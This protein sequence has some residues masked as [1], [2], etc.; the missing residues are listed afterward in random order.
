M[1]LKKKGLKCYF[2]LVTDRKKKKK[3]PGK[4][5]KTPKKNFGGKPVKMKGKKKKALKGP[6]SF[7]FNKSVGAGV[8]PKNTKKKKFFFQNAS[9]IFFPGFLKG[10]LLDSPPLAVFLV[11]FGNWAQKWGKK[12]LKKKVPLPTKMGENSKKSLNLGVYPLGGLG[13]PKR[14]KSKKK[15]GYKEIFNDR[16]LPFWKN[17]KK[18]LKRGKKC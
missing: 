14:K 17:L 4:K 15:K 12:N 1:R 11:F 7:F 13:G 3:K 18:F 16:F 6:H 2:F 10:T 9:P 5:K 8:P